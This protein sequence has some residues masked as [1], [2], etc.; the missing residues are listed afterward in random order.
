M[1]DG[2]SL[3]FLCLQAG[4]LM[5]IEYQKKIA[6]LNKQKKRGRNSEALEKTK[7]AVKYLHTRYMVDF[8][9]MDS[10]SSEIQRLRDEQLYPNLVELVEG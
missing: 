7:A 4:E 3:I 6:S 2:L 9:A 10:T 1:L 8:Q 5:K